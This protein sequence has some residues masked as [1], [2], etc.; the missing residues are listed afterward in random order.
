MVKAALMS[1]YYSG[2]CGL[3]WFKEW[4]KPVSA[5]AIYTE[6]TLRTN[7]SQ[8]RLEMRRQVTVSDVFCL[9]PALWDFLPLYIWL[10][11][12]YNFLKV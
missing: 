7:Y 12:R 2:C 10:K 1:Y 9:P 11:V 6:S 5:A 8:P 3:A 4:A